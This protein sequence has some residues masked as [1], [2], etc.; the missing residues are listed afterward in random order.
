[1]LKKLPIEIVFKI[2]DY[3]CLKDLENNDFLKI[4]YG[5]KIKRKDKASCFVKSY[6][7]LCFCNVHDDIRYYN[8]VEEF[9]RVQRQYELYGYIEYVYLADLDIFLD[10]K[11]YVFNF[12]II[13]SCISNRLK[14]DKHNG[15]FIKFNSI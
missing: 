15:I 14:F 9:N 1:M 11:K 10:L 12:G 5:K 6:M 4:V 13:H 8:A 7:D 3:L 2:D